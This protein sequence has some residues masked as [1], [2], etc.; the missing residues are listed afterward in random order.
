MWGDF[1]SSLIYS[2]AS[3]VFK[4][5]WPCSFLQLVR[6]TQLMLLARF[7]FWPAVNQKHSSSQYIS[8][9][10]TWVSHTHTRSI[11][12]L[13]TWTSCSDK[14]QRARQRT[15][16]KTQPLFKSYRRG[17][18]KETNVIRHQPATW[19]L[20]KDWGI[21]V[22][23]CNSCSTSNLFLFFFQASQCEEPKKE[24]KWKTADKK[25]RNEALQK[26]QNCQVLRERNWSHIPGL[27]YFII[28]KS[29]LRLEH[30]AAMIMTYWLT[31]GGRLTCRAGYKIFE[32]LIKYSQIFESTIC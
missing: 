22:M 5:L 9:K 15:R 17:V 30:R 12:I 16:F 32:I 20:V 7:Y 26:K 2:H 14:T 6:E 4:C 24:A 13:F 3:V 21:P 10:I 23:V 27:N 28:T 11:L 18:I 19:R 25:G 31:K 1:G 8:W 29:N